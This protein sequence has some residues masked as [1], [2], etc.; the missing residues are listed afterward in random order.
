MSRVLDITAVV[1]YLSPLNAAAAGL[2]TP[3]QKAPFTVPVKI[4]WA[5]YGAVNVASKVSVGINLYQ[6]A[7]ANGGFLLDKIRS[8]Y[9][10]NTFS[11]VTVYVTFV[12]TQH[13]VYALP[14]TA[15]WYPVLTNGGNVIV[16][17]EF[18]TDNAIPITTIQF[19]NIDRQGFTIPTTPSNDFD[20]TRSVAISPDVD[21]KYV[22]NLDT[23]G[24]LTL[25]GPG[26]WTL[27][28]SLGFYA[29]GE[30]W[31]PGG[32]AGDASINASAYTPPL[33]TSSTLIGTGVSWLAG[34]GAS[35][36]AAATGGGFS[37]LTNGGAG[38]N[39][40][41]AVINSPGSA[42]TA[43]T[44][45]AGLGLGGTGGASPNGGASQ[46]ASGTNVVGTVGNAPGGGGSGAGKLDAGNDLASGGGGGGAYCAS[47]GAAL[48]SRFLTPREIYIFTAGVP[49]AAGVS[50]ANT[51][52]GGRGA[53]AR[54]KL[55]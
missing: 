5:D 8:I 53:H 15:G 1:P 16:F 50:N 2:C 38:G 3:M 6:S 47:S 43:G 40:S 35:S 18:F 26:T 9:I 25:D 52:A 17:A 11:T 10:D 30:M 19:T 22:W 7:A 20:T 12:D 41:G 46:A 33:G 14:N 21:G 39:A 28:P 24:P 49:S 29:F 51:N 45:P 54:F 42:G 27:V 34:A 4:N 37:R 55:T 44:R 23:D 31:G 36:D 32:T 48:P 13:T